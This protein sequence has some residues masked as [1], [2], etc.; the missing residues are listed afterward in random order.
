[1]AAIGSKAE[2]IATA[3]APIRHWFR[4]IPFRITFSVAARAERRAVFVVQ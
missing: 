3:N 2:L 4:F 1:M